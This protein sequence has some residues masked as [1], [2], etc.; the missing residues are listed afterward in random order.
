MN[1]SKMDPGVLSKQLRITEN[2][3]DAA[4]MIKTLRDVGYSRLNELDS[5]ALSERIRTTKNP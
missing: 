5:N 2:L 3:N 4:W 1:P